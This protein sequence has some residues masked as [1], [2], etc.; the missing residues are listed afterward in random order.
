MW[1]HLDLVVYSVCCVNTEDFGQRLSL[2]FQ[3]INVFLWNGATDLC[4]GSSIQ[5]LH[6]IQKQCIHHRNCTY[7]A[8]PCCTEH[9]KGNT[10]PAWYV[11]RLISSRRE[12]RYFFLLKILKILFHESLLFKICMRC[13]SIYWM[14]LDPKRLFVIRD[15]TIFIFNKCTFP[16]WF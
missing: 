11:C 16:S 7:C 10:G 12:P 5:K 14:P 4:S 1:K 6:F 15:C 3:P 8:I 9:L 2:L 13:Y